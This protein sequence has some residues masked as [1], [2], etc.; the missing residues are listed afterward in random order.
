L[1]T[2]YNLPIDIIQKGGIIMPVRVENDG[3]V[4]TVIIDRPEARNAVNPETTDALVAAFKD[5]DS[6]PAAS[7]K[8]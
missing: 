5:F 7:V 4:T 6:D 1:I 2:D 3:P 8:K